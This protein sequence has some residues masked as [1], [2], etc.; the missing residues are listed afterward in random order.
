MRLAVQITRFVAIGGLCLVSLACSLGT[1]VGNG[2]K[3]PKGDDNQEKVGA[4]KSSPDSMSDSAS[5]AQILAGLFDSSGGIATSGA[6]GAVSSG[7]YG[8][9]KDRDP[10]ESR[11]K[12]VPTGTGGGTQGET[13]PPS[14]DLGPFVSNARSL[15]IV[16]IDSSQLQGDRINQLLI[17]LALTG[18]ASPLYGV[19][20]SS[21]ANFSLTVNGNSL[22]FLPVNIIGAL[23]SRSW[24]IRG[25]GLQIDRTVELTPTIKVTG[26][27][28]SPVP[29]VIP[30]YS[31]CSTRGTTSASTLP[32]HSGTF[33]KTT[34]KLATSRG[35]TYLTWYLKDG[36]GDF[37]TRLKRI[38]LNKSPDANDPFMVIA[39]P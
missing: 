15:A 35:Y 23:D 13:A 17:D 22:R 30:S 6:G 8:D 12:G 38:E 39:A 18:C 26:S 2:L 29:E 36:P 3:P 21:N 27:R 34:F 4:A 7:S 20:P 19:T 25:S 31:S 33:V 24:S 1:E 28:G 16:P 32:N 11:T 10:Y 5:E 14:E 9:P 37:I